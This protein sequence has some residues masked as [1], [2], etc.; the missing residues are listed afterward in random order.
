M[1]AEEYL[2]M[3]CSIF[4]KRILWISL[5]EEVKFAGTFANVK[6]DNMLS[7]ICAAGFI[8]RIEAEEDEAEEM[9]EVVYFFKRRK[10]T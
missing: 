2:T 4:L 5:H 3:N 9:Q 7:I 1:I 10:K 6:S 8:S